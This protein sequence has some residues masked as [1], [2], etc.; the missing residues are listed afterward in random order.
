M[1]H[2]GPPTPGSELEGITE[3]DED[4]DLSSLTH[5][6]KVSFATVILLRTRLLISS[7]IANFHLIF[8][9]KKAL[10][11]YFQGNAVEIHII[12]PSNF[13]RSM[14]LKV[15]RCMIQEKLFLCVL[16]ILYL[17]CLTNAYA[18]NNHNHLLPSLEGDSS[19]FVFIF[20]TFWIDFVS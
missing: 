16:Y 11:Q 20:M 3:G 4:S 17:C 2:E 12:C 14:Y 1:R 6:E 7:C 10:R 18:L 9:L 19:H 8:H 15:L 5:K 13:K